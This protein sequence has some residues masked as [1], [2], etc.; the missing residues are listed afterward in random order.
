MRAIPKYSKILH[1]SGPRGRKMGPRWRTDLSG[2]QTT[3]FRPVD[4]ENHNEKVWFGPFWAQIDVYNFNVSGPDFARSAWGGL[5]RDYAIQLGK[6]WEL[7]IVFR[8]DL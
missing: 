3:A 7:F 5:F 2:H 4:Y 1:T 6:V 8:G